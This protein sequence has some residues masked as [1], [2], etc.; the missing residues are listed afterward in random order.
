MTSD[1]MRALAAESRAAELAAVNQ[2]LWGVVRK[3]AA[4]IESGDAVAAYQRLRA[5]CDAED[6][7]ELWP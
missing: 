1:Y 5:L 2:I 4:D 6:D 7:G 3:A